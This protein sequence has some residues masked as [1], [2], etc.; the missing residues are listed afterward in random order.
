[1]TNGLSGEPPRVAF[2][3]AAAVTAPAPILDPA[4]CPYDHIVSAI[5]FNFVNVTLSGPSGTSLCGKTLSP[6]CNT[7]FINMPVSQS[8]F[9]VNC[10]IQD[11]LSGMQANTSCNTFRIIL[12]TSIPNI[13]C[14]SNQNVVPNVP[15]STNSIQTFPA[16]TASG[17][18]GYG[19]VISCG[20]YDTLRTTGY[21][22]PLGTTNVTC[23]ATALSGNVG[24]CW[25]TV[26]NVYN[27]PPS[28]TCP[29]SSTN[30]TYSAT[31]TNGVIPTVAVTY[32]VQASDN[33]GIISA[34][35][36]VT[37]TT[38]SPHSF[39][40]GITT[41]NCTAINNAR[42]ST[43]C[44]AYVNI[45]DFV[46]PVFKP[47]PTSLPY[48]TQAAD[49]VPNPVVSW[50]LLATDGSGVQS[51]VCPLSGTRFWV[52][53]TT[54]VT[55]TA[56]DN[57]GNSANCTF[58][59]SVSNPYPPSI[60]CPPNQVVSPGLGMNST[61]CATF[62]F[63]HATSNCGINPTVCNVT[64]P[65][66]LVGPSAAY[67]SCT[68]TD[69]SFQTATCSFKISNND[70]KP[71]TLTCPP[72]TVTPL[73]VTP[74]NGNAPTALAAWNFTATD[75]SGIASSFCTPP[76]NSTFS[77]G[78]TSVVC[79][80]TDTFGNSANC[81]AFNVY[82]YDTT[83][84]SF[85]CPASQNIKPLNATPVAQAFYSIS[86]TDGSGVA[87]FGCYPPSGTY[88]NLNTANTVVC[89]ATDSVNNTA[90]CSFMITVNQ[91]SGPSII[92][93]GNMV[94]ETTGGMLSAPAMFSPSASDTPGVGV[95]A[96][97]ANASGTVFPLG[98]STVVCTATNMFLLSSS[99]S[100][101]VTVQDTI[102]PVMTCPPVQ[103]AYPP[104]GSL[105]VPA[106]FSASASSGAG[107]ALFVCAPPNGTALQSTTTTYVTCTATDNFG[108]QSLCTF[109][110]TV[111]DVT[112]PVISCPA[113]FTV[114]PQYGHSNVAA[115]YALAAA[116]DNVAVAGVVCT[117]PSGSQFQ[118]GPNP[119]TC[120]ATDTSGNT[121][122]CMFTITVSSVTPPSIFCPSNY[123]AST[124]IN[125]ASG[126]VNWAQAT[127]FD[128]S[129]NVPTVVCP[130]WPTVTFPVGTTTVSCTATNNQGYTASCAFTV[131]IVDNQPPVPQCP[132]NIAN[133]LGVGMSTGVVGFSFSAMDNV[134]YGI[135]TS[136]SP[137]SGSVFQY[138]STTV[139]CNA[140]D[141]AGNAASCSFTVQVQDH[142]APAL[143]CPAAYI[144]QTSPNTLYGT[145]VWA[146]PSEAA[147]TARDNVGILYVTC[148]VAVAQTTFP[149][150]QTSITCWA[151]DLSL[152]NASCT[153][154]ITIQDK[155]PPT[156]ACPDAA[157]G[158]IGLLD[159]RTYSL[160]NFT[161]PQPPT[162]VAGISSTQFLKNGMPIDINSN[163]EECNLGVTFFTYS[164]TDKYGNTASCTF[165]GTVT[166]EG[167]AADPFPPVIVNC[168]TS[169]SINASFGQA[170]A[171]V[172]WDPINATDHVAV[173]S[174]NYITSPLGLYSGARFPIGNSSITFVATN[175]AGLYAICMFY[176]VVS[177]VEPPV[178]Y[179]PRSFNQSCTAPLNYA[180]VTW[181]APYF[182]DPVGILSS[183]VSLQPGTFSGGT[184]T[185]TAS[186]IDM[187]GNTASCSF[188]FT[189]VT[190]TTP[191][192]I[193]CPVSQTVDADS[194]KAT[195]QVGWP[196]PAVT[197]QVLLQS[198]IY[199]PSQYLPPAA[200]PLG[201]TD[202]QYTVTDIFLNVAV[203]NF[204]ITVY[205]KQPPTITCP[206]SL[207]YVIP[208]N[209]DSVFVIWQDPVAYDNVAVDQIIQSIA[210]GQN[211]TAGIYTI[212]A[213]ANDTSGNISPTC[214]FNI[215]V[216]P[217]PTAPPTK[218]PVK[219]Q[220]A[221]SGINSGIA[222]A[223]GAGAGGLLLLLVLIFVLHTRRQRERMR[224]LEE[225]YGNSVDMSDEAVLARAQAIQQ[226]LQNQKR[227]AVPNM[228][229][230]QVP[231]IT[232]IAP[233][234][235]MADMA[236]YLAAFTD[237]ELNRGD[238]VI[239]SEIGAGEFGSVCSG[240]VRRPDGTKR[241]IAIKTLKDSTNEENKVKFLQEASIMIQFR[242]PKIV[243]LVGV[244]T[245]SEPALICL[246]FCELG[247]L[248]TYLKSELVFELLSDADLIRMACD[249][250]S[251]M[252]YLGESGFVH[253]DLAARNVLVN[254]DFVCK[255]CDFGLSQE[256]E[257]S[258][259]GEAKD[260]KIPIRW[261]SPEAVMYHKFSTA[262]DVWSFG[263]LLWE[264]WAYGA[265]PYKGWTNDN[266]MSQI[267]KGYRMPA[268]KN[269]PS[270]IH[271]IMLDCWTDDYLE[272]PAFSDIFQ[273]L[274]AAW[275]I[276]K[277][278]ETYAKVY[279]YDEQGNKVA[280]ESKKS[281][282]RSN[283]MMTAEEEDSMY[284]LGGAGRR[285]AAPKSDDLFDTNIS[286][287]RSGIALTDDEAEAAMYDLGGESG[288]KFQASTV[289]DMED[290]DDE[291]EDEVRA[292]LLS[293]LGLM[294]VS[295]AWR[296]AG[297][298]RGGGDHV[299]HGWQ[300]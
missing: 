10:T 39:G 272:R 180:Y 226:A 201:V 184:Y 248:R 225:Q 173:A 252:H 72:Y 118:L 236:A 133:T 255:V 258:T 197:D 164:A 141:F 87:S 89:N 212:S 222:A 273:K 175:A 245:K 69:F 169:V 158:V 290:G 40:L 120:V 238:V 50:T 254:K 291:L 297:Q 168:P 28:I 247:S 289:D 136:C 218:K 21:S 108:L 137:T 140:T 178:A 262:S 249:V 81:S 268:P 82:V 277:P 130:L 293:Q 230:L 62:P 231:P 57:G 191:P 217:S 205:D 271:S 161:A 117:P 84:P 83:P 295:D 296:R 288:G 239:E 147:G 154:A 150:G 17:L 12:D 48:F 111:P 193:T 71:P 149:V 237:M 114:T 189:V 256:A 196:T 56:T 74:T 269:C 96:A 113:G 224:K 192:N 228:K 194:G 107:I 187:Y 92:C 160:L 127:A 60:K 229:W 287:G 138:G 4:S 232:F 276:C 16:I 208:L 263:I 54:P 128:L 11:T 233:P 177:D 211:F 76:S 102:K 93:P 67:V 159:L 90:T 24:S 105:T 176:I 103:Y 190:F 101:T 165:T 122:S 278:V 179:C 282:D 100:F 3:R 285:V 181:P 203:C 251:A 18:Y 86:P 30:N 202:M 125:A 219:Q 216:S 19:L 132:A 59:V 267:N 265:M 155:Q 98:V 221:S 131:T 25:F 166:K 235:N 8:P 266:V 209:R 186:A 292:L 52:G 300:R 29:F 15:M 283:T 73:S 14:P 78:M 279:V 79:G 32:A 144:G 5:G 139:M 124:S 143:S 234:R 106:A 171:V 163:W 23:T 97:C 42:L 275:T 27:S 240:Y 146:P 75:G 152:N 95:S 260:E 129:G 286:L 157:T 13:T 36:N 68:A 66:T 185:V 281:R 115:N 65:V 85:A 121:A 223:A 215:T 22:F 298:R 55:C 170:S 280:K 33:V 220:Q 49:M 156:I 63:P 183:S 43:S 145:V 116:I 64:S 88:F 37:S 109:T 195:A 206:Q 134:P 142:E 35:C 99:C 241:T 44:L 259:G 148:T 214:S 94:L 112:P 284:D 242:H 47:C 80:A 253:R 213:Y 250:C 110:V 135:T 227:N 200:F 1:M 119:V 270:Y 207:A 51:V 274:L 7:S 257:G 244:V 70:T 26:T 153:F 123:T 53:T 46:P 77:F 246:E 294:T 188:T 210:P 199:T 167:A 6:V 299:R 38:N 104:P 9:S 264:M 162:D 151:Y 198:N 58:P 261:T 204:Q 174:S 20:T 172:S 126:V 61:A 182:T 41:I 91:N 34:T 243:A 45:T 31:P 2:T